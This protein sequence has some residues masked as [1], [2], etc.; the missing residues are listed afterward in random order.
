MNDSFDLSPADDPSLNLLLNAVEHEI[1]MTNDFILPDEMV[2]AAANL[3]CDFFNM[4]A[5]SVMDMDGTGMCS[6]DPDS[7]LDDL[8]GFN[9]AQLMEMGISG[10]DSLTLVYAHECGHR[11]LQNMGLDSWTEELACDMFA[12]VMAGAQG[13]DLTNFEAALGMTE[14]GASHP[15][16][17]L[18]AEFVEY[19][20]EIAEEM[21]AR[22]IELS[23]ENCLERFQQ[24]LIDK[25]ALIDEYRTQ[26]IGLADNSGTEPGPVETAGGVPS[27]HSLANSD[28]PGKEETD[29]AMALVG[30]QDSPQQSAPYFHGVTDSEDTDSKL[31]SAETSGS[32]GLVG[33]QD[34]QAS[35]K[36]LFTDD[37]AW[38]E[39]QAQTCY[40]N[41]SWHEKEA[42]A[43]AERGDLS[44]ANDHIRSAR[45]EQSRGNDYKDAAKRSTK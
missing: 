8:F 22:G 7:L 25:Y 29:G 39:K 45:I 33:V 20:K 9:R 28:E 26:C 42:K 31:G 2:Q 41:A 15:N 34:S 3:A 30:Q 24:H 11:A 1:E 12:G 44:A 19:G 16:G 23:Y 32:V 27:L 6:I 4:P 36:G 35:F 10:Q 38:N 18:R 5:S 40:E 14:G 43:A 21:N 17:A 37:R 13:I